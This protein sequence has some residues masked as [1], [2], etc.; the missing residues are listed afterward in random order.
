MG[1]RTQR[2]RGRKLRW[3]I[4]F[5]LGTLIASVAGTLFVSDIRSFTKHALRPAELRAER[6]KKLTGE[7]ATAASEGRPARFADG[8]DFAWDRF[9]GFPQYTP[10]GKIN[11][12]IGFVWV[13]AAAGAQSISDNPDFCLFLFINEGVVV[14]SMTPGRVQGDCDGWLKFGPYTRT[15]ASFQVSVED[16]TQSGGN[17]YS[18]KPIAPIRKPRRP[19][20]RPTP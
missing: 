4:A 16:T 13:G 1:Q 7:I 5:A 12:A 9:Y 8:T 2:A 18:L 14:Q 10:A 6:Q 11:Q 19:E 3:L 15:T 17:T 20:D